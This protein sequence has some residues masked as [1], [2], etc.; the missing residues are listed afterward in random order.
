MRDVSHGN[1]GYAVVQRD[2]CAGSWFKGH[3]RH[4]PQ[5]RQCITEGDSSFDW[6]V[7]VQ[8]RDEH[9]NLSHRV[10]ATPNP[11]ASMMA[12]ARRVQ[13]CASA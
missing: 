5:V 12:S 2:V 7:R 9:E 6:S 8:G 3:E 4:M 11:V 1:H 10:F 13:L